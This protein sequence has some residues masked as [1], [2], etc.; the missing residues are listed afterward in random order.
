MEEVFAVELLPDVFVDEDLLGDAELLWD[1]VPCAE[2]EA[3]AEEEGVC[4][5]V[6][7]A[8]ASCGG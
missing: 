6:A 4:E 2:L 8:L 1:E 5:L 7:G 3:W